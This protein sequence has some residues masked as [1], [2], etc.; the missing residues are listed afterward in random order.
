MIITMKK[1][2]IV[3]RS[4]DREQL[5]RQ[6]RQLG[7]VHITPVNRELAVADEK[8]LETIQHIDRAIQVLLKIKPAEPAPTISAIDAAKE[9]LEIQQRSAER[10]NRLTSLSQQLDQVQKIWGDIEIEQFGK[11]A[12]A[13]IDLQFFSVPASQVGQIQAEL[14]EVVGE[15]PGKRHLVAVIHRQGKLTLP[16]NAEAL[17]LPQTDV[18][19]IREEAA[20]I[21]A[22]LKLDAD[23]LTKLANLIPQMKQARAELKRDADFSVALRSAT[24]DE[25]LYA[26]QGWIPQRASETLG[27]DLAKAGID[28]AV[29]IN[30]PADDEEPPT[31]IKNPAW[32]RPIE[33]LFSI[34]GTVS[35]YREAE[36]SISFM[37]ALPIFASMLIGDTGYGLMLLL[38]IAVQYKKAAKAL[39]APLAQLVMVIAGM[40]MIWGALTGSFFGF[41]FYKPIIP[42]EMTDESRRMLMNI[43]FILGTIHLCFAHFWQAARIFPDLKFLNQVGWGLCTAGM[44]GVVRMFVLDAPMGWNTIWPYL[45]IGGSAL[46][47]LFC[48]PNKNIFKMLGLGIANFPFSFLSVFSDIISYVRLMAVGLA[49]TVLA[50]AFN[51][52][53]IGM[54]AWYLTVP[55]L[56]AGHA[57]NL[58]LAM[59]ALFAHGVRLNMLE[60]SNNLGMQWT[61]Y[62]YKPFSNTMV[63][64]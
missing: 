23:R 33:G 12:E 60:F 64:E 27:A 25:Q 29:E 16:V 45:L 41:A 15:L 62:S 47:M 5:L 11:I 1:A 49:G 48:E 37:I 3:A 22:H 14:A 13:G 43:S 44:F 20:E 57:L 40:T 7:V 59:I 58:G 56:V 50:A 4:R 55:V 51:D 28:A 54:G 18:K 36:V 8:T 32:V 46:A 31:L 42:V 9:V 39:G 6:L 34:L 26:L 63:Q 30:D 35:G 61:G 52:L 19:T 38:A 2:F 24:S 10:Q 21:D 17:A 53:A